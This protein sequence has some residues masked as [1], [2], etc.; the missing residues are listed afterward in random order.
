[1]VQ[2]SD[3][4]YALQGINETIASAGRVG[5]ESFNSPVGIT[6]LAPR[7]SIMWLR[8]AGPGEHRQDCI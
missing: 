3:G 5:V 6:T 1:M 2:L 4:A 7:W 8:I